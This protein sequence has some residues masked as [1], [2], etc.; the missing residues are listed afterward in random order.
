MSNGNSCSSCSEHA[1]AD[2]C[3]CEPKI[4]L[5]GDDHNDND[6]SIHAANAGGAGSSV[7]IGVESS[8]PHFYKASMAAYNL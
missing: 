1:Q 8:K 3:E 2:D 5:S 4:F 7:H 6:S